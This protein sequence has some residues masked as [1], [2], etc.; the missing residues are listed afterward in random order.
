MTD[1][2]LYEK[3]KRILRGDFIFD[4]EN[5]QVTFKVPLEPLS[6]LESRVKDFLGSE[7]DVD[8]LGGNRWRLDHRFIKIDGETIGVD[9]YGQL[10]IVSESD[11]TKQRV[12][13]LESQVKEL[14]RLIAEKDKVLYKTRRTLYHLMRRL[15]N[16]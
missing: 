11:Y 3:L 7:Y 2:N 8:P 10:Q 1:E 12:D 9:K 6:S 13:K 15:D 5:K 16:K 4:E 14:T